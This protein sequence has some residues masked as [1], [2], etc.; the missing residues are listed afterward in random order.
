MANWDDMTLWSDNEE[1]FK[2]IMKDF[3]PNVRIR[4][5]EA[6]AYDPDTPVKVHFSSCPVPHD[7]VKKLSA[8]HP[9][10]TF[11]AV[12]SFE[13]DRHDMWYH[14]EYKAGIDKIVNVEASYMWAVVQQCGCPEE[15]WAI[16][17][18]KVETVFRRIDPVVGEGDKMK[19]EF[20]RHEVTVCAEHEDYRIEATKHYSE[21]DFK[22]FKKK[23]TFTWEPVHEQCDEVPF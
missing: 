1:K 16:L 6:G 22:L 9:D 18:G 17:M 11:M 23:H 15:V 13:A 21:V 12:C 20:C 4:H 8:Q 3:S 2:A 19:I 14:V 7:D 5:Q 10:M